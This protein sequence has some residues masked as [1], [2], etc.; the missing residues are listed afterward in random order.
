ML[1]DNNLMTYEMSP[2]WFAVEAARRTMRRMAEAVHRQD[3]KLATA[4]FPMSA[5]TDIHITFGEEA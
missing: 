3:L 1:D 4:L 2:E 5:A